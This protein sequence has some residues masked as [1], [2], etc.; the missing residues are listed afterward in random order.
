MLIPYTSKSEETTRGYLHNIIIRNLFRL[1]S[2]Y[3]TAL[4][5]FENIGQSK[6]MLT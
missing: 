1:P 5:P 4:R 3:N 6:K 2:S